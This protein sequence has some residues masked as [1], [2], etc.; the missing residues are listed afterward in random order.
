[1]MLEEEESTV[2]TSRCALYVMDVEPLTLALQSVMLAKK[3]IRNSI[4]ARQKDIDQ[5]YLKR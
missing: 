5:T 3:K 2:Q 1:M 4:C